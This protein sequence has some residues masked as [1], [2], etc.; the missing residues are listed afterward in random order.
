MA[1]KE[2]ESR[3]E[4]VLKGVKMSD[5]ADHR[6]QEFSKGMKQRLAIAQALLNEPEILILDEPTS[7]LDPR[8][9]AEVRDVIKALKGEGRTLLTISPLLGDVQDVCADVA[10]LNHGALLIHGSVRNLSHRADTST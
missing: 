4:A 5:W 6:I 10:L 3:S 8:G 2:I 9:M 1:S 7:G